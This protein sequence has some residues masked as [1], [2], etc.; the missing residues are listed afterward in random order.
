MEPITLGILITG[1]SSIF[2]AIGAQQQ[3]QKQQAYNNY[4]ADQADK[5]AVN[6]QKTG[7]TQSE[8][9]QTSAAGESQKVKN[10]FTKTQGTQTAAIAAQGIGLD[11]VTAQDLAFSSLSNYEKDHVMIK[12]N[13]NLSSWQTET[14]AFNEAEDLKSKAK[15]YRMA[16]TNAAEAGNW[17][18]AT[19]ILGGARQV[20]DM[21]YG[22]AKK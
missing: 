13:A 9:I 2:G 3:G 20:A 15:G 19:S 17:N 1:L 18:A 16:G 10:E 11:S 22:E 6:V 4:M 12:H 14:Q 8:L 21:W 7:Q 5:L